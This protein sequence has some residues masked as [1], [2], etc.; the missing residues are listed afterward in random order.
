MLQTAKIGQYQ[1][2]FQKKLTFYVDKN[3]KMS[4]N[5]KVENFRKNFKYTQEYKNKGR[6]KNW[7]Q[8]IQKTTI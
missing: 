5:K 2:T 1:K 3:K 8:I 7:I 4:Y 6:K